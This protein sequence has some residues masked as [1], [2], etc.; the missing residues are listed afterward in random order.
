MKFKT[1]DK[2]KFLNKVGGGYV[3]QVLD[4]AM[5]RIISDGGLE[6]PVPEKELILIDPKSS[7]ERYFDEDFEVSMPSKDEL[8]VR[9]KKFAKQELKSKGD[10]PEIYEIDREIEKREKGANRIS[11]PVKLIDNA[12]RAQIYDET[13]EETLYIN[14]VDIIATLKPE[15]MKDLPVR[16]VTLTSSLDDQ[17]YVFVGTEAV[18]T[19]D[20]ENFTDEDVY[21]ILWQYSEDGEEFID[22]PDVDGL[23]YSYNV[24]ADNFYNIWKITITLLSKTEE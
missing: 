4:N 13:E 16:S 19:A 3:T 14:L 21:S 8:N 5:V 24:D 1:G 6:Y 17:E 20:L 23:T 15:G 7:I 9:H 2:V 12:D 18:L 22:I 10:L 11:G